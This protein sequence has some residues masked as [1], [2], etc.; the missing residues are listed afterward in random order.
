MR[1]LLALLRMTSSLCTQQVVE[2]FRNPVIA[3]GVLQY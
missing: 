1:T 2:I 3:G